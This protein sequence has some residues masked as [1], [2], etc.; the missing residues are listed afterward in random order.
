VR[1]ELDIDYIDRELRLAQEAGT[2]NPFWKQLAALLADWRRLREKREY[3]GMPN[4]FYAATMQILERPE[5]PVNERPL[6]RPNRNK[7]IE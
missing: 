1:P 5:P 6:K 2:P 4:S 3:Q 7:P